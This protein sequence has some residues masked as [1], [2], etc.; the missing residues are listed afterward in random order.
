MDK[1]ITIRNQIQKTK[2][3]YQQI[4]KIRKGAPKLSLL[5]N[6]RMLL[7]VLDNQVAIMEKLKTL[8]S[9]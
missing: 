9:K 3:N 5:D 8:K 4:E 2:K 6:F 1:K 7:L